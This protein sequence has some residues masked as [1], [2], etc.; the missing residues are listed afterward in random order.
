MASNDIDIVVLP[1]DPDELT[2]EYDADDNNLETVEVSDVPA[3]LILQYKLPDNSEQSETC[4]QED[5]D[6]PDSNRWMHSQSA[7]T[8][9]RPVAL[10][11][12]NHIDFAGLGLWRRWDWAP[13][14]PPCLT[15]PVFVVFFWFL[16]LVGF[17]RAEVLGFSP[18]PSSRSP[19]LGFG[20]LSSFDPETFIENDKRKLSKISSIRKRIS[21]RRNDYQILWPSWPEAIYCGVSGYCYNFDIYTGKSI[22]KN[23]REDL[24]LGSR[25]GS[26]A[27]EKRYLPQPLLVK[28]YNTNMGGVDQH[29]WLIGKYVINIRAKKWYWPLFIRCTDMAMVN[30]WL[31]YKLVNENDMSLLEYRRSVAVHY[32]KIT[33]KA[34]VGREHLPRKFFQINRKLYSAQLGHLRTLCFYEQSQTVKMAPS[35]NKVVLNSIGLQQQNV[36][37][38][39]KIF[40]EKTSAALKLLEND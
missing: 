37:L 7:G 11:G 30:S 31:L 18:K 13:Q 26:K 17:G 39:A 16:W 1:P 19:H 34:S 20:V 27:K 32:M 29:D 35:L 36:L 12:R 40:E 4:E 21:N 24:A 3:K 22:A 6:L 33:Q 10:Q 9:P 28:Q 5:I 23:D 14:L 15:S 8:R 2:D 38:C 25:A